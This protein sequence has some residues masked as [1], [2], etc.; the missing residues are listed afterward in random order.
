LG[1]I[2][3][4]FKGNDCDMAENSK[5]VVIPKEDAVFWMDKRGRWHNAHGPFQNKKIIDYFHA[6]IR[7]DV[8]GFY[9][10]QIRDGITEKVY[11]NYE[12]TA[13]FVFN[14]E[15]DDTGVTLILNTGEALP[16]DPANLYVHA[17]VLIQKHDDTLIKF[18]DRTMMMIADLIEDNAGQYLFQW[19]GRQWPVKEL[20]A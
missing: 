13:L 1:G 4:Q 15:R 20:K 12:K 18:T 2:I 17:D 3:S 7:K 19:E 10:T 6:C 16:L 14:I 8:D 11:F 9:L 5:E